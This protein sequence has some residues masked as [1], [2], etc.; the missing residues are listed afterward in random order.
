MLVSTRVLSVSLIYCLL[1]NRA[2]LRATRLGVL[3]CLLQDGPELSVLCSC[4]LLVPT[5]ISSLAQLHLPFNLE[6]VFFSWLLAAFRK[7]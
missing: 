4:Y 1:D 5:L 6:F 7:E 2:P 3:L